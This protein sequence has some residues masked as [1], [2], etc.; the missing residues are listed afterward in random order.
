MEIFKND[1]QRIINNYSQFYKISPW[2][3][4]VDV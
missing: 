3:S 1:L 4:Q 2:P